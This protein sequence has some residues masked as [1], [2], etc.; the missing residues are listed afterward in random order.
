MFYLDVYLTGEKSSAC[1]CQTIVKYFCF[2]TLYNMTYVN[3]SA[4][5]F[6]ISTN[7]LDEIVTPWGLWP[8]TTYVDASGKFDL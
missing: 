1:N 3:P 5:A 8:I 7:T 2:V 4:N 6:C